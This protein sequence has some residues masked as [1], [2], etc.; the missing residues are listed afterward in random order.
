MVNFNLNSDGRAYDSSLRLGVRKIPP[1]LTPRYTDDWTAVHAYQ[2]VAKYLICKDN[3]LNTLTFVDHGAKTRDEIAD[4]PTTWVP[5]WDGRERCEPVWFPSAP[6]INIPGSGENPVAAPTFSRTINVLEDGKL[7]MYKTCTVQ[8]KPMCG[9]Y[10]VFTDRAAMSS[11]GTSAF[12]FRES[13]DKPA[14][15]KVV[16]AIDD[17]CQDYA[18]RPYS[19]LKKPLIPYTLVKQ[20]AFALTAGRGLDIDVMPDPQ[21]S[22]D[23]SYTRHIR[24][25]ACWLSSL[26]IR[27]SYGGALRLKR[28]LECDPHLSPASVET[29]DTASKLIERYGKRI[30]SACQNRLLFCTGAEEICLGH[31]ALSSWYHKVYSLRGCS[32]PMVLEKMERKGVYKVIGPCYV[33]W[34]MQNESGVMRRME[35]EDFVLE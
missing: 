17:A 4:L 12:S 14:K 21:K 19:Y 2:S 24:A 5:R 6:S 31:S 20:L 10:R 11:S 16:A 33:N 15:L 26:D 34:R 27:K 23:E 8:G 7:R 32:A 35:W 25:F 3:N 13:F 18:K 30:Y 28:Q 9:I 29:P 22:S 1:E